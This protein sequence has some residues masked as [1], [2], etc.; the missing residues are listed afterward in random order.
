MPKYDPE[1]QLDP[2]RYNPDGSEKNKFTAAKA[3]EWA[4]GKFAN[5]GSQTPFITTMG[6]EVWD[7]GAGL[8]KGLEGTFTGDWDEAKAGAKQLFGS[9]SSALS[10]GVL[11]SLN[12]APPKQYVGGSEEAYNDRLGMYRGGVADAGADVDVGLGAARIAGGNA[13]ADR[14][15]ALGYAGEGMGIGRSGI[16]RQDQA[17]SLLLNQA[18]ARTPSLAQAQLQAGLD[19]TTRGMQGMAAQT[20]GGNQAAAMRNAA[21]AGTDMA[22][23]TNQ[24]AAM[25]RA[26]EEAQRQQNI[27]NAQQYAAGSYGNRAGMGYEMGGRGLGMAADST[28]TLGNLG[29]GYAN[30]GANREGTYLEG[31]SEFDKAQ[32]ELE[33]ARTKAAAESRGGIMG[34]VG[35]GI[36][37]IFGG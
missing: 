24:Q 10:G 27:L 7:S 33:K 20:R 6:K 23:Q 2:D 26:Q 9:V 35:K 29:L 12:T 4:Q 21:R 8:A 30:V 1:K 22:L 13:L 31:L 15:N 37:M 19:Q 3:D 17:L 11:R 28:N 25:L 32:V 14:G 34:A 36:G 5:E 18:Q 16:E